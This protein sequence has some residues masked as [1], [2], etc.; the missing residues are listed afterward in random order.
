[1]IYVNFESMV[2]RPYWT[3]RIK[4]AWEK[5]PIVWL[6][7]VR[8]VGKTTLTLGFKEAL[9]LNCD[10]PTVQAQL[11]SPEIFYA[12]TEQREIIFD[13]VHQLDDPS[14]LLKIG[15]DVY[16]DKRI[17]A[18]GSSTLGA[19]RKFRDSLT[20]RKRNICLLPVLASELADFGMA[21]M[22]KRLLH[23]GMPQCLLEVEPDPEF[24]S[25]WLDSY[26]ARD[27]QELFNVGK[28]NGFLKLVEWVLRNSGSL[29]ETNSIC[30]FTGLTRPTVSNYLDILETTFVMHR[31]RPFH[32][33]GK[34]ELTAQP[35]LYGFD[36][37][38]VCHYRGWQQLRPE[39][40]GVLLEHL[41]LDMLKAHFPA[42]EILYWRDQQKRELD[43][44][45]RQGDTV[46]AI[47]CKWN[48]GHFDARN[49]KVFRA[50]YPDGKNIL[51]S[52]QV[53]PNFVT[54]QAGM[55]LT[56]CGLKGLVDAIKKS[57]RTQA[58]SR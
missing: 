9:Y 35:K 21:D 17:I 16:P 13:E 54:E 29:S 18:T 37:G 49:L 11:K 7:G 27:I 47:E 30:K 44:V 24:F 2:K 46:C 26:Y 6:A 10:L 38:F 14:R 53:A 40:C 1:M 52:A 22:Q 56:C 12:N 32:G 41:T 15:S 20:G 42:H 36:T 23:G 51:V 45:M 39:D 57:A 50:T 28:R 33:G 4:R 8:R 58:V 34:R 3:E 43:F 31:L 5:A 19:T 25:E 55:T 48:A